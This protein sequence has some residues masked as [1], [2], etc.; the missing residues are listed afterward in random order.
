MA[1][2]SEWNNFFLEAKIPEDVA[3]L[4]AKNFYKNRMSFDM[5]ADLTK[6]YLKDLDIT[7]LGDI[8]SILKHP[9]TGVFKMTST[10][11]WNKFF[12]DAKMPKDDA[13]L[14]AKNFYENRM[15]FGMLADL[16]KDYL[17]HLDITALG[18]IISILKHAKNVQSKQ[19]SEVLMKPAVK[20]DSQSAIEEQILINDLDQKRLELD[21]ERLE[22]EKKRQSFDTLMSEKST[23]LIQAN[24]KYNKLEKE[25]LDMKVAFCKTEENSKESI[26]E[27]NKQIKAL[28]KKV[29]HL[30]GLK[31]DLETK[32]LKLSEKKSLYKKSTN[33]ELN[34][35]RAMFEDFKDAHQQIEEL[36]KRIDSIKLLTE[37]PEFQTVLEGIVDE[38]KE[39]CQTCR[40]KSIDSC[41]SFVDSSREMMYKYRCHACKN[42]GVKGKD[43]VTL[44]QF[45]KK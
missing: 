26:N 32:N 18:D 21:E 2:Q 28:E 20:N 39:L 24:K 44:S 6:D 29:K 36:K 17:R 31:K 14:Y 16:T 30:E 40:D 9:R 5:L 3:P 15:S 45:C 35:N 13:L 12:L 10:S 25:M 11:E 23:E 41:Q 43:N 27:A 4:Y 1:S 37:Y 42:P 34:R 7:V 38:M 33:D 19:D 8:I 22:L